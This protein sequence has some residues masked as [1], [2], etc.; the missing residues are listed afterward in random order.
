MIRIFLSH[1]HGDKEIADTVRKNLEDWGITHEQIFQSSEAEHGPTIGENLETELKEALYQA[2]LVLL[3]FTHAD[4]DWSYCTWECGV[5]T[6]PT[7]GKDGTRLIVL[8]CTND[9]L[10]VLGPR[11]QVPITENSVR[12]FTAQFHRQENFFPGEEAFLPRIGDEA[13]E[14]RSDK[15]YRDLKAII[16]S[17]KDDVKNRWS[18]ISLIFNQKTVAGIKGLVGDQVEEIVRS[19]M[20]DCVV[21]CRT[22][23]D[24]Y[25]VK[26][27]GYNSFE[28]HLQLRDIVKRWQEELNYS[29]E[30][31]ASP[32]WLL[33]LCKEIWRVTRN[34]S[35]ELEWVAMQSAHTQSL[36]VYPLVIRERWMADDSLELD[37]AMCQ[38]PSRD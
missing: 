2:K 28:A 21:H 27:F 24:Q 12:D 5:A 34:A 15:L 11:V 8:Q 32:D 7:K 38:A 33:D 29:G 3:T 13:L 36:W 17:G 6:D 37:V 16:P 19:V 20:S 10:R 14:R 22:S 18:C 30:G 23:H 9:R 25:A 35:S 4:Q 26:H 31:S 1:R